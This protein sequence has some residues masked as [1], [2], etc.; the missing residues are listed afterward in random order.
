MGISQSELGQKLKISQPAVSLSVKR[1][2]AIGYTLQL[3]VKSLT[4]TYKLMYVPN[5]FCFRYRVC[6]F[7]AWSSL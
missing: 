6:R 3:L 4:V 1:L 7:S 5:V 2:R